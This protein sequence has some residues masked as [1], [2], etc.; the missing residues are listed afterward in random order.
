MHDFDCTK[1][2]ELESYNFDLN[3]IVV[4]IKLN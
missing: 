4:I 3:E 1:P 2:K